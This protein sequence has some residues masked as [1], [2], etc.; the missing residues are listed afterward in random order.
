MCCALRAAAS[1]WCSV[2]C[3]FLILPWSETVRL[4][5]DNCS[6]IWSIFVEKCWQD[7]E[8]SSFVAKLA[9]V[10]VGFTI[11]SL[12]WVWSENRSASYKRVPKNNNNQLSLLYSEHFPDRWWDCKGNG[13]FYVSRRGALHY[14]FQ[15]RNVWLSWSKFNSKTMMIFAMILQLCSVQCA[16]HHNRASAYQPDKGKARVCSP[17]AST[18][19]RV[20]EWEKERE[21]WV[22]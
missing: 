6:K 15:W 7:K 16:L 14:A 17:C 11:W 13:I 4:H 10:S 22:R 20:E 2:S 21:G 8:F 9:C 18:L 1:E 12:L 5:D 19:Q 3:V